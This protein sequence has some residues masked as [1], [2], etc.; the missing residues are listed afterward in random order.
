MP[1]SIVTRG[2][3][4]QDVDFS[5]R[6]LTRQEFGRRLT[7]M[8]VEKVWRQ[9][10]LA[11]ASGLGRDSISQYARGRSIPSPKNLSKL[12]NALG[13]DTEVLFPNYDAQSNALDEAKLEMKS[14]ESD[15]KNVW[16]RVNMKLPIERA[17]EVI[18]LIKSLEST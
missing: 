17:I 15:A 3:P 7:A 14:I 1:K 4:Y 11:R 6:I 18:Q 13:V 10:G 2:A 12:A 8:L 5:E 9:S 16:L